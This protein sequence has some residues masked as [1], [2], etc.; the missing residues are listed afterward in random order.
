MV[1]VILVLLSTSFRNFQ[2]DGSSMHP[3]VQSGQYL[4]VNKAAY[5]DISLGSWGGWIPFIDGDGDGHVVPFG[6]PRRGDVIVLRDPSQPERNLIKRV[7]GL[8]GET[9]EVRL[10][11]VYI[12]DRRLDEDYLVYRD[13]RTVARTTVPARGYYVMGDER[14]DS[15]DSRIIGPVPK[16]NIIGKA[17]VTYWPVGRLGIVQNLGPRL[18]AS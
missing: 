16:E 11:M 7:I 10:G 17:W 6:E 1:A 5:R 18:A 12:N 3:N 4:V 13:T 2:V 15:L 8:P 9:V 14:I